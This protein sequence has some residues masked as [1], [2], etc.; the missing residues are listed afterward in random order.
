MHGNRRQGYQRQQFRE[1]HSEN[2][3]DDVHHDCCQHDEQGAG[4]HA[5][6]E[7]HYQEHGQECQHQIVCNP[8]RL[9]GEGDRCMH[10]GKAVDYPG[11][12]GKGHR[13][14]VTTIVQ[15][16]EDRQKNSQILPFILKNQPF[17]QK[18]FLL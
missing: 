15:H 3:A 1:T 18:T 10:Q 16:N 4:L 5:E 7:N 2:E 12:L 14:G 6:T 13:S 17:I 8:Q 9:T 11:I